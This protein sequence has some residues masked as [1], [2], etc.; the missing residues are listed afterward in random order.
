M[1]KYA[2]QP[3]KPFQPLHD[4]GCLPLCGAVP[5]VGPIR[6]M[7]CLLHSRDLRQSLRIPPLHTDVFAD[8]LP[9]KTDGGIFVI[10]Q[11]NDAQALKA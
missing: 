2:A 3:I 4:Q 7:V 11:R 5:T 1:A 6:H 10:K 8:F 9:T